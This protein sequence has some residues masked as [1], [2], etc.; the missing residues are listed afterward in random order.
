VINP[1]ADPVLRLFDSTR[2]VITENDDW[3]GTPEI[4]AAS[5]QVF[6][7]PL[8]DG[9]LDAAILITLPP[10]LYSAHLLGSGQTTGVGLIEV[11]E[12]P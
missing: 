1:L 10:G 7:F 9:S 5:T 6:A 4:S 3:G 2:N 8:P 12:A 11:Y